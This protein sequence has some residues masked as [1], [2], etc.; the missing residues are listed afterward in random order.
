[1]QLLTVAHRPM[2]WRRIIKT[3]FPSLSVKELVVA[4]VEKVEGEDLEGEE[5]AALGSPSFTAPLVLGEWEASRSVG[6]DGEEGLDSKNRRKKGI[7]GLSSPSSAASSDHE[8]EPSEGG[9]GT[10]TAED[11]LEN[12]LS[13]A[14]RPFFTRENTISDDPLL[15]IPRTGDETYHHGRRRKHWLERLLPKGYLKGPGSFL[16]DIHD[17]PADD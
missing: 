2:P 11:I 1:M 10:K 4:F 5:A 12:S 6:H 3:H 17:Y 7:D 14:A 15:S 9:E 16:S 13:R 8:S